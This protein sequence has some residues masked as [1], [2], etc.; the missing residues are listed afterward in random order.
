MTTPTLHTLLPTL[1]GDDAAA[2]LP[3]STPTT[4]LDTASGVELPG[5]G[6]G[7]SRYL[8]A[9]LDPA[10]ADHALERL[11]QQGAEVTYQQWYAMPQRNRP[12]AALHPLR[13]VKLAMATPDPDTGFVP[14][15]RFPVNDQQRHGVL[16]PMTPT[17]ERIQHYVEAAT[18]VAFN[19]AVILLY[20]GADDCIGFHKDKLLDLDPQA[21]IVSVSL[22]AARTYVWRDDMFTP[23]EQLELRLGHGSM[24]VLGPRTNEALYHSVRKPTSEELAADASLADI[25]VSLTFRKVATF[26]DA[27]GRL[28][29]QGAAYSDLNWP[30][31][32]RGE[33]RLDTDVDRPIS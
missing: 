14:H 16:V 33:H 5:L 17:V 18:G 25:R 15:Y 20:R 3:T 8:P 2:V 13:R 24:L 27:E 29:G 30:A 4:V 31:E 6:A 9:L 19:H 11:G 1:H 32:L 10:L 21:P 28:H 23:T 22:G 12:R 7:D 26:V